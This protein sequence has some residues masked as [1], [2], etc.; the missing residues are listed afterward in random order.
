[1]SQMRLRTVRVTVAGGEFLTNVFVIKPVNMLTSV[2][3]I[4]LTGT[5]NFN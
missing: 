5:A 2:V 3:S 4:V 1:M